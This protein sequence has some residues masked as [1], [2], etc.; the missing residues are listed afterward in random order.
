MKSMKWKSI[1]LPPVF[2][3]F[4]VL[5]LLVFFN[6]IFHQGSVFSQPDYGF[7][8]VVVPI[9]MLLA[10]LC[11][12]FLFLP[13]WK[14]YQ[15]NHKYL[16]I[17]LSQLLYIGSVFVGFIF[18]FF[19]WD[20]SFGWQDLIFTFITGTLACVVFGFVNIFTLTSLTE[21]SFK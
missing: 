15:K 19:L 1:I 13:L 4:L 9:G 11:Q 8:S 2:G 6:I 21:G 20:K 18:G 5:L 3:I 10:I 7:L 17:Q 14:R 16:G 12:K